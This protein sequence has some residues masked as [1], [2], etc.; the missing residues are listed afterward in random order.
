MSE[1]FVGEIRLFA[2]NFAPLDWAFC[3]GQLLSTGD[4]AALFNLIGTTYGGDGIATFALPDLR[5][6]VPVHQGTGPTGTS[7]IVG[8]AGGEES[9]ALDVRQIPAHG[10]A[11]VARPVPG[12]SASPTGDLLAGGRVVSRYGAKRPGT[13][14]KATSVST[15]GGGQHHTNIQPYLALNFIMALDGIFPTQS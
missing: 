15:F 11:V 8:E 9:V 4:N 7:Y 13:L 3:N 2:G 5:S 10:H 14:M 6:R 12:T 1:P